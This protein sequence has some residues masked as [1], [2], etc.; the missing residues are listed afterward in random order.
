MDV[1][2][3]ELERKMSLGERYK[4]SATIVTET[5]LLVD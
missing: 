4:Y 5:L 2:Y 3:C 1:H